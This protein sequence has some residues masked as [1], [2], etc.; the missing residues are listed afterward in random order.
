MEV[1]CTSCNKLFRVSDDKITG[2]GIKFACT[3]C[4]EIVK[5]TR[6]DFER[7]TLSKPA[8]SFE[9]KPS[10]TTEKSPVQERPRAAMTVAAGSQDFDL[11]EPAAA[12]AAL[13]REEETPPVFVKPAP[14]LEPAPDLALQGEQPRVAKAEPKTAPSSQPKAEV[15]VSPKRKPETVRPA[16]SAAPAASAT[17]AVREAA[18]P[19]FPV[20]NSVV[21]QSPG[22]SGIGKKLAV[23]VVV[24]VVIG[25]A[26][27]GVKWYFTKAAYRMSEAVKEVTLPD[28]LQIQSAAGAID[29]ATGDLVITG[30]I[31]NI[32]DK[33]RPAWYVVAEVYDAQG[34]VLTR[35][36]SLSGKQLYARRDY[37]IMAK[38]G[39]NIQELKQKSLQEQGSVI[40]PKGTASFEMRIM[41]PPVGV[42]SFNATL[43]SFD[44]VQL[45]KEMVDEQKQ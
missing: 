26:A 11:S 22:S 3:R 33:P 1:R 40:P 45:F 14:R 30:V 43:Q 32:T 42:A 19:A 28:G 23:L 20:S 37:E 4:S 38:R 7:Y 21:L 13:G 25:G 41:E 12:A 35:G 2:S 39:M 17:A 18:R 9:H 15:P 34:V 10:I 29:P 8:S 16:V 6:E 5:I 36:K 24:L 31:E 44:P 27:F